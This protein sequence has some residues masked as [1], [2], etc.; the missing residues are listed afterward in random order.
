[1]VPARIAG[2]S[3]G[4][5]PPPVRIPMTPFL[6]LLFVMLTRLFYKNPNTTQPNSNSLAA[7]GGSRDHPRKAMWL[8]RASSR[9]RAAKSR[10]SQPNQR[11]Q[12]QHS[13]DRLRDHAV[14]TPHSQNVR[15]DVGKIQREAESYEDRHQQPAPAPQKTQDRDEQISGDAD[16]C[17]RHAVQYSVRTVVHDAAVPLIID[18]ARLGTGIVVDFQRQ[19]GNHHS[20]KGE[21]DDQVAHEISCPEIVTCK[22]PANPSQRL[23]ANGPANGPAAITLTCDVVQSPWL[24]AGSLPVCCLRCCV[25]GSPCLSCNR[26]PT[27][28]PHAAGATASTTARCPRAGMA[29]E[30]A[31]P[32]VRTGV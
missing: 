19:P 10:P 1:M 12:S 28:C 8:V 7:L 14:Q 15:F 6:E 16:R 2:F 29:S 9:S 18:T 24:C 17:N 21:Q 5:S 32:T 23:A 11:Q 27:V 13:D 30:A 22:G 20:G 31:Q 4:T 26:N 25:S 3:P